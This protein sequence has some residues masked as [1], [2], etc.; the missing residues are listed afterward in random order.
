MFLSDKNEL[1]RVVW[2]NAE[3]IQG[4]A[5]SLHLLGRKVLT[6]EPTEKAMSNIYLLGRFLSTDFV[7]CQAGSL[8]RAESIQASGYITCDDVSHQHADIH[9]VTSNHTLSWFSWPLINFLARFN[10]LGPTG[11]S[12]HPNSL[13]SNRDILTPCLPEQARE[14]E[15]WH[16]S[17]RHRAK[18]WSSVHSMEEQSHRH[19]AVFS[20]D[21]KK[22]GAETEGR[23]SFY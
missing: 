8:C 9:N 14:A 2:T 11:F 18:T 17:Q 7:H 3:A 23:L 19:S 6:A 12:F 4:K 13:F 15:M 22:L 21:R 16:T 5:E 20:S 1:L 10:T